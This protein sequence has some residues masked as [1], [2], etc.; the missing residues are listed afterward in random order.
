VWWCPNFG[1]FVLICR[2]DC[3]N[4]EAVFIC[5]VDAQS[6]FG[7]GGIQAALPIMQTRPDWEGGSL[8]HRIW[9]VA[10]VG[11]CLITTIGWIGFLVFAI[12]KLLN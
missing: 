7:T 9:P 5:I 1:P 2:R 12:I 6:E 4:F 3:P 8:F 11:L 10:I